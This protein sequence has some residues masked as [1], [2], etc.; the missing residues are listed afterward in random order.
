MHIYE[1]QDYL[2]IPADM[3]DL[4]KDKHLIINYENQSEKANQHIKDPYHS[5]KTMAL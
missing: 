3:M 1:D 4:P 2:K 5:N